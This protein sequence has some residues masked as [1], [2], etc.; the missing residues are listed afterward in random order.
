MN[1]WHPSLTARIVFSDVEKFLLAIIDN[2]EN[3]GVLS[4]LSF[5]SNAHDFGNLF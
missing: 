4:I 5:L 1:F 3:I 2:K